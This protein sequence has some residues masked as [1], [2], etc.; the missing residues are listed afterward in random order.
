VRHPR[1]IVLDGQRRCRRRAA[2]G[3]GDLFACASHGRITLAVMSDWLSA[4]SR[5][6][7]AFAHWE[8][9]REGQRLIDR[10]HREKAA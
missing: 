9:A 7:L 4:S 8:T 2:F 5:R 6:M 1:C 3:M 10:M